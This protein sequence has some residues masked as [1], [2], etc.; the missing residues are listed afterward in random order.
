MNNDK[1]RIA[2]YAKRRGCEAEGEVIE[3]LQRA[4]D[5]FVGTLGSR[6]IVCLPRNGEPHACQRHLHPQR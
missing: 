6:E 3:I 1:V 5:T 4:N 2:F